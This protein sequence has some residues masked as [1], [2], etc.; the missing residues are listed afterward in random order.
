MN[1]KQVANAVSTFGTYLGSIPQKDPR[2][3]YTWTA[4]VAVDRLERIPE[5]LGF[6]YKGVE[7][8]ASIETKNWLKS[9]LYKEADL[10]KPHPKFGKPLRKSETESRGRDLIH[11]SRKVLLDLVRD[12]DPASLLDEI[13]LFLAT[14]SPVTEFSLAQVDQLVND[15]TLALA[16]NGGVVAPPV[17][18]SNF[19]AS[20]TSHGS[21][22][23]ESPPEEQMPGFDEAGHLGS[24]LR[25]HKQT[26]R[27]PPQKNQP[28]IQILRRSPSKSVTPTPSLTPS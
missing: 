12:R 16:G 19:P 8:V 11:V 18:L 9:P 20:P 17:D 7:H 15:A 1:G 23:N 22:H 2:N 10:P 28:P 21:V 27:T 13:Q 24:K 3:T 25:G 26:T 6:H 4:V 5:E 14:D